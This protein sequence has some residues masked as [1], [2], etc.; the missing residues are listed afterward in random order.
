MRENFDFGFHYP[1]ISGHF[2][3]GY[4]ELKQMSGIL[5]KV[6]LM[7][8]PDIDEGLMVWTVRG[9][10]AQRKFSDEAWLET[11]F[12][13]YSYRKDY[14]Y[15]MNVDAEIVEDRFGKGTFKFLDKVLDDPAMA[16][17]E[18]TC[19]FLAACEVLGREIVIDQKS[20]YKFVTTSHV[21]E[22]AK[23]LRNLVDFKKRTF[24]DFS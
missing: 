14:V 17:R 24:Y 10:I 12:E 23:P 13:M 3:L 18:W 22:K 4:P 7:K 2:G 8:K 15:F 21:W 1:H 9:A 5:V 16:S 11:A 19:Q 6:I 20:P